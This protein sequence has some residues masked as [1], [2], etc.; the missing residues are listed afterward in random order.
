M[1]RPP[2]N[3]ARRVWS[4]P[5][6]KGSGKIA[7]VSIQAMTRAYSQRNDWHFSVAEISR[8]FV[9]LKACAPYIYTCILLVRGSLHQAC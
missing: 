8:D 2:K 4:N 9:N 1:L 6:N 5:G 7:R 3:G